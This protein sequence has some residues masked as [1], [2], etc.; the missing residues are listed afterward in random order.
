M[1]ESVAVCVHVA[2]LSVERKTLV[3]P[4]VPAVAS[5]PKSLSVIR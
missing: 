4:D 2:P 3:R 5:L 1:S